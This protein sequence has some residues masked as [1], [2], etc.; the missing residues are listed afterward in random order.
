MGL[1]SFNKFSI[2]KEAIEDHRDTFSEQDLSPIAMWQLWLFVYLP[3]EF[4]RMDAEFLRKHRVINMHIF[5]I[6]LFVAGGY[7]A[8]SYAELDKVLWKL[9][10]MSQNFGFPHHL[11]LDQFLVEENWYILEYRVYRIHDFLKC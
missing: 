3:S 1:N 4:E 9:Y 11:L 6:D 10:F 7:R 8:L 5:F 2:F